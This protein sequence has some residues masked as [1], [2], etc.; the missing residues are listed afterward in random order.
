MNIFELLEIKPTSVILEIIQAANRFNKEVFIEQTKPLPNP[1]SRQEFWD[2]V[3][4]IVVLH[5]GLFINQV[6]DSE[7]HEKNVSQF[8]IDVAGSSNKADIDYAEFVFYNK[9]L[10]RL[11]DKLNR[12]K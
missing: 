7:L 1:P 4:D 10:Q 3:N 5:G 2:Y 9:E 6:F 12:L 11:N 8:F